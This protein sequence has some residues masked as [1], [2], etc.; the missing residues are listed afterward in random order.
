M[1]WGGWGIDVGSGIE[2][3]GEKDERVMGVLEER[4]KEYVWIWK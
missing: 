4:M 1:R 2:K 3:K